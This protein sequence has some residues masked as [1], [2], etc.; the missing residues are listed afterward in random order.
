MNAENNAVLDYYLLPAIDVEDPS[1]R[2]A[3]DN[4]AAL[5][6]Y[7][8]DDLQPFFIAT[9]RSALPEAV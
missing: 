8:F 1:L 7:R 5:D 2:L 3:M 6:A 9:G 4:H